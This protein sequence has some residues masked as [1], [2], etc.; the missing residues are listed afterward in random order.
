MPAQEPAC[1]KATCP[2]LSGT[3]DEVQ[4]REWLL[5]DGL[6]GFASG[7]VMGCPTRRYHGLLVASKRPPLER[8]LLLAGTLDTVVVG[9]ARVELSTYEFEDVLH[10]AGYKL[11]IG[12]AMDISAPDPWVEFTF[13]HELFEARKRI[14]LCTGRRA[15]RLG[16]EIRPNRPEPVSLEVA[17]LLAM[18][19]FHGVRKEEADPWELHSEDDAVWVHPRMEHEVTLAMFASAGEFVWRADPVW[20]RRFRH[21]VEDE[22][23]FGDREDLQ[24]AGTFEAT[25]RETLTCELSCVG[26]I[27]GVGDARERMTSDVVSP[28][29]SLPESLGG[30]PTARRLVAAAD[31]FVVRRESGGAHEGQATII[32]GYPWFGDWGRDSFIALE[33]LLLIP[34]RYEEARQVLATFAGA[35]RNGLIPNR[36]D[37][38][39]GE[40]AYNSVD[41]SLWFIHAADAYLRY[42]NDSESWDAFLLDACRKVIDAFCEGT[43][44]DI[45]LDD[46][47]LVCC[48]NEHTQIT[49]MDAA[50]EGT[51]FTPRHGRPVEV[52]ALWYHV[53][54]LV[55]D[56]ARDHA[57]ADRCRS[58]IRKVGPGFAETFWNRDAQCLY[59]CVRDDGPD[60]SIRPNQIFAVSLLHSPLPCEQRKAVL[61]VVTDE[62]LTP[63]GLRSLSPDDYRYHPRFGETPFERDRS[64]HNGTVWG[65][66][67][68]P[69]VEAHLRVQE[70][71]AQA[72]QHGRR[73]LQPLIDH[74]SDAGL[75]SV[76]EIFDAQAPHTPRGC[77]AQAWSVAE[78]LRAWKLT[79]PKPPAVEAPVARSTRV[80]L[81]KATPSADST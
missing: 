54:H 45:H 8:Y 81:Q 79:E 52:N 37:D 67:I 1:P 53:L 7:S 60:G 4:S 68:G 57:L 41:A 38:Y 74:L 17:P 48:G 9:P 30:D 77:P 49:W 51:V 11:L 70:F 14:T 75:G 23:G 26:F 55:A 59:D 16:Y 34:G 24:H 5:A 33:G 3:I 18:R 28:A 43:D 46:G 72:R 58:L 65:W 61:G 19:D 27:G 25:G 76:S 2:E 10:P 35:Q 71:S 78:V 6:G 22:R 42:S 50:C 21:R 44:F 12:F 66:L 56:R 40:C 15:V 69:Y 63:C 31:Q 20:W 32:A 39:G 29:W 80:E 47:G 13:S 64:Y 62:L 73:L 36:F